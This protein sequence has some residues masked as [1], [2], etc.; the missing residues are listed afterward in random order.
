MADYTVDITLPD[1]KLG[2]AW[3]SITFG[4]ITVDGST[5]AQTLARVR[6]QFRQRARVYTLDSA[7]GD[8][9][10]PITISNAA[11]WVATIA[12]LTTFL[13]T[14]GK[15]EWDAEFYRTGVAAPWT[16]YKG[17]LTVHPQVT[18]PAA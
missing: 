9:D 3:P 14:A 2:D 5:P 11:T 8:R 10:A 13:P 17:V 6:M 4:P 16:L 7:T 15:W 1:W 12:E 18:K